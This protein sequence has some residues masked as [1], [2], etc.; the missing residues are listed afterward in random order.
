MVDFVS[1]VMEMRNGKVAADISDKFNELIA[2]VLDT[3]GGGKIAITFDVKPSRADMQH[4]GVKEVTMSHS[5]KLTKPERPIGDAIFFIT[6]DG[7]LSRTDPE[8]M[9]MFSVEVRQ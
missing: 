8:Q 1:T 6:P 7:S 9:E 3:G 5:V 4:G 2:A